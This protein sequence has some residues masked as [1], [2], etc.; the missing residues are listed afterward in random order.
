MLFHLDSKLYYYL[1]YLSLTSILTTYR[2]RTWCGA[3]ASHVP[4]H[5]TFSWDL[6]GSVE[7][8]PTVSVAPI[9]PAH[10]SC[11]GGLVHFTLINLTVVSF[12]IVLGHFRALRLQQL[13]PARQRRNSGAHG[14]A[15]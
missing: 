7:V 14:L 13:W 15:P 1:F 10:T 5:C 8:P 11:T 12:D 4:T 3:G 9:V 6:L 2:L